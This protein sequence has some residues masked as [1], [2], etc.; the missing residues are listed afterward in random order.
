M[1][2]LA[3]VE[4]LRSNDHHINSSYLICETHA[5]SALGGMYNNGFFVECVISPIANVLAEFAFTQCS[6][7]QFWQYIF[8]LDIVFWKNENDWMFELCSSQ[9]N[10]LIFIL[11][12]K[13]IRNK[14]Q[15]LKFNMTWTYLVHDQIFW[16]V[17][18]ASQDLIMWLNKSYPGE[19]FNRQFISKLWILLLMV[20]HP[21]V[22]Y[23]IY[24]TSGLFSC[25]DY[26]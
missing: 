21:C 6:F 1:W 7:S 18:W 20:M 25:K 4:K 14:Q 15:C 2:I 5:F 9:G 17:F 19:L 12:R 26:C 3:H 24:I 23:L 8:S 16:E 22:T 13:Y 10:H 11:K